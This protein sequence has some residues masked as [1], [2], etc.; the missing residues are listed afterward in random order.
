MKKRPILL[1]VSGFMTENDSAWYEKIKAN[2]GELDVR[3][4]NWGSGTALSI[5]SDYISE[6]MNSYMKKFGGYT[7]VPTRPSPLTGLISII[8]I[9][10]KVRRAWYNATEATVNHRK[11]FARV[12]NDIYE[13]ERRNVIIIG[14]SLGTRLINN[15]LPYVKNDNVLLTVSMAGAT[16]VTSYTENIMKMTY[17]SKMGNLNIYSNND[18]VLNRIYPI[19]ESITPIG[20]GI[21]KF[22]RARIVNWN[23][24]IGHTEYI[25]SNRI[26][27][28]IHWL[29]VTC[30]DL[31]NPGIT[32][33]DSEIK[34]FYDL[35]DIANFTSHKDIVVPKLIGIK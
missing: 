24:D 12:I 17:N 13:K 9:P 1:V 28:L 22:K 5:F 11:E 7:L 8:S 30:A 19:V 29:N 2:Y 4:Y 18:E 3:R 34:S 27:S 15:A 23:W 31:A 10:F 16:P 21:V 25:T 33:T 32:V 6:A 14:H 20:V 35:I 26:D